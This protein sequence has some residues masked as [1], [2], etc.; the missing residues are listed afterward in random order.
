MTA[1]AW[2]PEHLAELRRVEAGTPSE[3]TDA[4]GLTPPALL[5]LARWKLVQWDAGC[6]VRPQRRVSDHAPW[7]RIRP[8]RWLVTS[9]GAIVLELAGGR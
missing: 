7:E 3:P 2:T 4:K 6:G 5:D 1:P 8:V 9:A